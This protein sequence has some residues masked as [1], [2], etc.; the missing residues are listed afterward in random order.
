M[1]AVRRVLAALCALVL[2]SSLGLAG[3]A[4][5]TSPQPAWF[6]LMFEVVIAS[7]CVWGV[8]ACLGTGQDLAI[9]LLCVAICV[10]VGS[11][12][13]YVSVNGTVAGVALKWHLLA[14]WAAAALLALVAAAETLRHDAPRSLR[15]VGLGVALVV[16]VV[17]AAGLVA[18]GVGG[19]QF[20]A[21]SGL[22][23]VVGACVAFAVCMGLLA[24]GTH[25]IMQA[26]EGALVAAQKA[27][28]GPDSAAPGPISRTG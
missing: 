15:R 25:A 28:A 3:V 17:V 5:L 21:L 7:A 14:R 23:R 16:P 11:T 2:L 4:G 13:G 18:K 6:L 22:W 1:V 8:R 19:A 9:S 12:L 24:A 10:L 27:A 26:F 20:A